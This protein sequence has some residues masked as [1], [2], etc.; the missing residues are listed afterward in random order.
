MTQIQDKPPQSPS[1][2]NQ[3]GPD[4]YDRH[5]KPKGGNRKFIIAGAVIVV[6]AVAIVM[7]AMQG[8]SVYYVTI[9]QFHTKQASFDPAKE[10]RVAGKV[11]P[12]TI[13]QDKTSGLSFTAVDETDPSQTM[14]V[15]YS[16]IV[17][18]TFKDD[19]QVVVTGTYNNGVFSANEMLAKC[20]SK[21]SSTAADSK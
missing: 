11:V 17:P 20:P 9:A 8:S 4:K 16:K 14:R 5:R 18:D 6:A 13:S 3:P 7:V 10:V 19:A 12:G 21:Y 1:P 15:V 2:S